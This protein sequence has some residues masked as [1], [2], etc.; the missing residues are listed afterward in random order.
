MTS[1]TKGSCNLMGFFFS[2]N[3]IVGFVHK[4]QK[5]EPLS[6]YFIQHW[7]VDT[8]DLVN[9]N[10]DI[11]WLVYSL[12]FTETSLKNVVSTFCFW[13]GFSS[14]WTHY[15]FDLVHCFWFTTW[16]QTWGY[17]SFFF[18]AAHHIEVQHLSLWNALVFMSFGLQK[19]FHA[20]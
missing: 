16:Q 12:R 10:S 2:P 13:R 11:R 9:K 15:T 7:Q 3:V 1:L 17:S 19:S 8:G 6:A 20:W 4:D 14:A 18:K 5:N